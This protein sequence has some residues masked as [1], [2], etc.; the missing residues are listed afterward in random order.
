MTT[1]EIIRTIDSEI[2]KL[3]RA[4]TLLMEAAD[5]EVSVTMRGSA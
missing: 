5:S 3:L 2:E 4:R 1:S